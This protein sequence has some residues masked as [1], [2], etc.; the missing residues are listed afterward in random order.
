[1]V[2]V[3]LILGGVKTPVVNIL[4]MICQIPISCSLVICQISMSCSCYLLCSNQKAVG[5]HG[6]GLVENVIFLRMVQNRIIFQI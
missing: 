4:L 6:V 5:N 1:V 3:N 2:Y